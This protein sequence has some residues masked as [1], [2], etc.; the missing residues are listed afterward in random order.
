MAEADAAKRGLFGRFRQRLSKSRAGFAEPI[1]QVFRQAREITDDTWDELEALL[2]Q[3]DMGAPLALELVGHMRER[4]RAEKLTDLT[5]LYTRMEDELIARLR[6]VED[7]HDELHFDRLEASRADRPEGAPHVTLVIGVNG[8]GKTTTIG[9]LANAWSAAGRGVVVAA[10]DTFRAAALEQ[11]EVWC[12][13]AGVPIVKTQ[14]GGDPAAVCFDA[15]ASAQARGAADLI[16]DTA[17]RLQ[18]K[19]NLMEELKKIGRVLQKRDPTAPHDVWLVIDA[20]TGQNGLSQAKLFTEALGVTGIIL[21]KLDGTAKGGIV[22]GIQRELSVPV[23]Y[24][25]LG[26]GID[27]LQ[28]FDPETYVRALFQ[29]ED[30]Y[31]EADAEPPADA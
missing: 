10:A 29:D 1:K 26:E 3:S 6:D 8:A 14:M 15:W 31:L 28:P 11:L 30:L 22:L 18:T 5:Q 4:A 21:T 2:I 17:G 27:D 19:V 16:I 25:G 23:R 24:V 13:R 12:E 7:F 20:T 9:K